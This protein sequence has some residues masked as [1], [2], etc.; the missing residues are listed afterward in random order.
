MTKRNVSRRTFLKGSALAAAAT[1][2]PT[3][4][5]LRAGVSPNERINIAFIGMGSRATCLA[6]YV[7]G[8]EPVASQVNYVAYADPNENSIAKNRNKP[9]SSRQSQIARNAEQKLAGRPYYRDYRVML[10]KHEKEIDAVVT[11]ATYNANFCASRWAMEMGKH[12]YS[13]KATGVTVEES[14]MMH[15]AVLKTKCVTQM[16]NNGASDNGPAVFR[17]W[18]EGGV[19]GAVREVHIVLGPQRYREI[20]LDGKGVPVPDYFDWDVFLGV[21]SKKPFPG[22]GCCHGLSS[23]A[24]VLG[25][26][27]GQIG[28]WGTHTCTGVVLGLQLK[29]PISVKLVDKAPVP[30]AKDTYNVTLEYKY[31]QRAGLA[32]CTVRFYLG[33]AKYTSNRLPLPEDLEPERKKAVREETNVYG[34]LHGKHIIFGEKANAVCGRY[35][36]GLRIVPEKKMQEMMP[37]IANIEQKY[38]P[39]AGTQAHA[40]HWLDCIRRGDYEGPRAS[41]LNS[42]DILMEFLTLGHTAFRHGQVD[43]ELLWDAK[44]MTFTNDEAASRLL[45]RTYRKEFVNW[46]PKECSGG[47]IG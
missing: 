15:E 29:D 2:V 41:W 26:G 12:A 18:V 46:D 9:E 47:V 21:E 31:P 3:F 8:V 35:C 11:A 32:P 14:R 7:F 1:T 17:N 42:S 37:A 43:K 28:D 22:M 16:G 23:W 40:A 30:D 4:N 5:I 6:D 20:P 25:F 44:G 45:R 10:D 36:S 24:P 38:E 19:F 33:T 34:S 27:I 13:E 39:I